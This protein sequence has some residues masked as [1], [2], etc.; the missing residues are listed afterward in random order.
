MYCDKYFNI[1]QESLETMGKDL[2]APSWM[3]VFP[4]EVALDLNA[5]VNKGIIIPSMSPA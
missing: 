5:V 3:A 1:R 2:R 4:E